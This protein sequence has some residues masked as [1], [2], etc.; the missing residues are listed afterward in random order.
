MLF[1]IVAV[2]VLGFVGYVKLSEAQVS[3]SGDVTQQLIDECVKFNGVSFITVWYQ[4][5][6]KPNCGFVIDEAITEGYTIVGD[7][8][9]A[10][11]GGSAELS[12]FVMLE[13]RQ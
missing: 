4:P 3:V 8:K 6:Y 5:D 7:L 12:K 1:I 13:R 10:C 11:C 9:D 2:L